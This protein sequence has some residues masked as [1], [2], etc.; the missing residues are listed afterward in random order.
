MRK[1]AE[2]TYPR[3]TNALR[4]NECGATMVEAALTLGI[5]SIV[6]FSLL[7]F[8]LIVYRYVA[9]QH[10]LSVTSRAMIT[11]LVGSGDSRELFMK[12]QVQERARVYGVGLS[13]DNIRV[14]T[15]SGL[16]GSLGNCEIESA[17]LP[18]Q[19]FALTAR[20]PVT[21]FGRPLTTLET[22]VVMLNEPF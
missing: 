21:Y 13:V 5:F 4:T 3:N 15:V 8:T 1:Y 22:S 20:M 6:V 19:L 12:H 7:E 2:R 10:A 11:G 16:V 14:C 17:G 18:N 9:V